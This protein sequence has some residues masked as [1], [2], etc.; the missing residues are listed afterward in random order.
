MP[1]RVD[2]RNLHNAVLQMGAEPVTIDLNFIAEPLAEIDIKLAKG[3][4]LDFNDVAYDNG[5]LSYEGRQ[6]LLYIQDHGGSVV[7]AL[8]DGSKGRKFHVAD[9]RTLKE[10]R[11]K[12]RYQ[13]YVAT[14][15]LGEEFFIAGKD[16]KS[17][18]QIEGNTKLFKSFM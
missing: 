4:E 18:K 3:I 8:E 11:D 1:L 14:N 12:G 17:G 16:W 9:C 13:R 10:M 2:L 6:V 7:T 15:D 5:L